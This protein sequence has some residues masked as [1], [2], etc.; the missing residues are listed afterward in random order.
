MAVGHVIP[1]SSQHEMVNPIFGDF[2]SGAGETYAANGYDMVLS[3]V[4]DGDQARV[5]RELKAKG[6]VD[7]L[8]LHG[9]AAREPRIGLLRELNIPFCV[10][11]RASDETGPYSWVDVNNRSAFERATELLAD[12]GHRRIALLNGLEI[13]DFAK[14]RRAGFEAAM[15]ARELSIEPSLMRSEEMTEE[16]GYASAKEMLAQDNPPTAFVVSSMISAIGVRRAVEE[17]GLTLGGDVSVITH[18][19]DLS[20]LRNGGEVPLF[21]ATR[22]SV[23]EAGRIAAQLLLNQIARPGDGLPTR[24]LEAPLVHGRSTG[25]APIAHAAQ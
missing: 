18:D 25:P 8:I 22:S 11:G 20:Y 16:Y 15:H 2:I 7:G 1:K 3:M 9:P 4:E 12:L 19:D 23:R 17:I 21:T 6:S 10:H 5:Y 14:R 24:L 13:M